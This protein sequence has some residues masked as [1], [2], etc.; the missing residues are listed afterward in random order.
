[1][2]KLIFVLGMSLFLISPVFSQDQQTDQ[3]NQQNQGTQAQ[4]AE[5]P[6]QTAGGKTVIDLT[7]LGKT[8]TISARMELP[9]VRIFEKRVTPDF[10]EVSADKSFENELAADREEVQYEPITS[11]RVDRINN[12]E[13]LLNKKRF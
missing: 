2:S 8:Y 5:Q 4:Q 12:M 7:K 11:G 6:Q 9:Q 13:E 10:E 1:M 3:Q